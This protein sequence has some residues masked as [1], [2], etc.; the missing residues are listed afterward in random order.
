MH[1][2]CTCRYGN[3]REDTI[4]VTVSRYTRTSIYVSESQL[5]ADSDD[6]DAD[7]DFDSGTRLCSFSSFI[8]C[9]SFFSF[10]RLF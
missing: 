4:V 9:S 7:L 1:V 10:I 6:D 8:A 5:P 3:G 2:D